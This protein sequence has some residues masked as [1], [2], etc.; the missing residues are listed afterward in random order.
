MKNI[1]PYVS[2]NN[3]QNA[4]MFGLFK[5]NI[6]ILK[7][8]QTM[9]KICNNFTFIKSKR[10][11]PNL[12]KILTS[13]KF[14]ENESNNYNVKKC[15]GS[16]CGLCDYLIEGKHY[17]FNGKKFYVNKNM[18]CD[19]EN[20]IYVIT[21]N[22]CNKY[23]IVQTGDKLRMRRTVH[24]QQ[25]RDPSTRQIPLSAHLDTFCKTEPKFSIFP[26]YKCFSNKLSVRLV[27][28]NYFIK[29]FQPELNAN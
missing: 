9:N 13:A 15:G 12:K 18:S 8:D 4:R 19:V 3:P 16:K 26:F 27:K 29:S 10:Q 22:G 7:S 1:I 17:N 24:A 25:I 20:V 23:Y 6:H 21:C 2:T 28:E 5:N 14:R 11:P